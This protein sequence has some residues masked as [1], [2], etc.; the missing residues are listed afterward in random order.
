[1]SASMET[2]CVLGLGYIGLPTASLL[3]A[4]GY[5]VSG[6][7]VNAAVIDIISDG[8]VPIVEP[9][10]D[11]LVRSAV[12]SGQLTASTEPS[13]ADVFII[14]VPTPLNKDQKPDLSYI[15]AAVVSMAPYLAPANLVILESTSPVGTTERIATQLSELRPDLEIPRWGNLGHSVE[16]GVD[17]LFM[18]HCPERVLPGQILRELVAN[19]RVVG[20]I[21][22]PSARR[23]AEFYQSFVTGDVIQTNSRVAELCKLTEN[24]CRDVNI[25]FANE[26]SL[27]CDDLSI[28]VWELI[29]LANRHPRVDILRPGPG[30]GG[31]CIAVDP[32]FI[33]DSCGERA[34][35]IRTAREVNDSKP[36]HVVARVK[37]AAARYKSPVV[38]CLGLAFKADIDDLRESPSVK[39]AE[40]LAKQRTG[41][42]LAVEPHI[43]ELPKELAELGVE[44]VSLREAFEQ[45][46]VIVML[47]NHRAFSGIDRE[48]LLSKVVIDTCGFLK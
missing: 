43:N 13:P 3:A 37:Q 32:W 7:D 28:N 45:A 39:I 26:L 18:A 27:I 44:L 11:V 48:A 25:A 38:T 23:A 30:V 20:G 33:V 22:E 4:K 34:R 10:L 6:V 5:T 46:D 9:E 41:R 8:R 1:M 19:D 36:K 15:D 2:I 21:D 12:Q 17:Q 35:L 16:S 29:K 24:A 47:V 14:A 40:E 31:H 42:I